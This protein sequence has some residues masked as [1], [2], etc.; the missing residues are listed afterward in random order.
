MVTLIGEVK[1]R[2]IP[3]Y[4]YRWR[5]WLDVKTDL[6]DIRLLLPGS[7]AQW[8]EPGESVRIEVQEEKWIYNVH[9]YRLWRRYEER[10][11]PVIPLFQREITLE[12]KDPVTENTLYTYK[13]L[14]REAYRQKDFEQIAELEQ[15][16]YAS[17][18]EVVAIWWCKGEYVESNVKPCRDAVLV[19]IKGSLPVSRFIVMELLERQPFEPEIVGY[20]RIDP[21]V[22]LMHRRVDGNVIKNIREKVF[23]KEWFHPTF[24]PEKLMRELMKHINEQ[25]LNLSRKKVFDLVRMKAVHFCNTAVSRIS[26]VVIH[27]DYRGDGLGMTIVRSAIEWVDTYDVPEMRKEKQMIETIAQMARYH[28][29]FERVG[30]KYLWDTAS[31]RPVLYYPLTNVARTYIERFLREDP[32]ARKHGGRLYRPVLRF[33]PP[34]SKPIR[35]KEVVKGYES[36][37]DVE[38]LSEEVKD[39]LLAFGVDRRVVQKLVLRGVNVEVRP[40]EIAVVVGASGAGKTTLLRLLAGVSKPDSG[41]VI[42]PDDARISVL[43]PG[44]IEPRFGDEALIEHIYGKTKNIVAAIEI[45]NASG[46]SDAV[47]YRAKYEELSTGQ[48][49]RAKIASLLAEGPNVLIIDE[50]TAHLDPMTA[51][52]VARKLAKIVREHGITLIVA[53]HRPEVISVLQPDRVLYVGYGGV[54]ETS[55]TQPL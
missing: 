5:G 46:L 49:E 30:F 51:K 37:L 42:I 45:L 18:K 29:F 24:W 41:R 17:K 48:K 21:P 1:R 38:G 12:K 22:P 36:V 6:G 53:T 10:W 23:P 31:G 28:P 19:E 26:R 27:P 50:F 7:I 52:R 13:L 14:V 11:V 33:A 35:L 44:E 16:H 47:F 9:E 39:A 3:K 55:F 4:T 34:I 32:L 20:L 40:G 2:G 15:Y 25:S 8:I 43:I 54:L